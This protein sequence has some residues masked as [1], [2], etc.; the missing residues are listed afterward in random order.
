LERWA[1]RFRL[2]ER[3]PQLARDALERLRGLPLPTLPTVSV[4][5]PRFQGPPRPPTTIPALPDWSATSL[6]SLLFW[7]L[8][9]GLLLLLGWH[10][11]KYLK[12]GARRGAAAAALGPWPVAPDQVATRAELIRA[13]DYLALLLLGLRA[14]VW[15]HRTVAR[16][17]AERDGTA[18]ARLAELYERARYTRGA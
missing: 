9:V 11:T 15:N 14:K 18:A 12:P 17:L 3:L 13:F 1:E 4:S 7:L 16:L 6:G 2:S 10:F 8:L 5:M